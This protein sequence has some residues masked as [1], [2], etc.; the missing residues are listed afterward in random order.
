MVKVS[1]LAPILLTAAVLLPAHAQNATTTPVG[2][3][4]VQLDANKKTVISLPLENNALAVGIVTSLSANSVTDSNGTFGSIAGN[5]F[6]RVLSGNATGRC[7]RISSN[8]QTSITVQTG[9]GTWQLPVDNSSGNTVNVAV[10]DKFEIVPMFT[11]ANVF[12]SNATDSVLRT[13]TNPNSADQVTIYVDGTQT[14]YFNNGTNWRNAGNPGDVT[15]YNTL[16]IL[17]TAGLAVTRRSTGTNAVLEFQGT[18]PVIAPRY[19]APGGTKFAQSIPMPA[20]ATLGSLGFAASPSWN[21]SNNPNS[22]DQVSVYRPDN[23][24]NTYFVNA[25]GIWRNAGN[26]GDT[27]DYTNAVMPSGTGLWVVRRG[28]TSGSGA[29]IA[30]SLPYNPAN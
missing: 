29:N 7:F 9:T 10:G 15:N 3:V 14:S 13:S 22:A 8:T 6:L 23:S 5:H 20:G 12:G 28:S 25:S 27:T 19:H 17:P 4:T 24:F 1:L 16:G 26:P 30:S 21:K 18:V 11:L 2:V